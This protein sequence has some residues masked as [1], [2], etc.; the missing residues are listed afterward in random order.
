MDIKEE[1]NRDLSTIQKLLKNHYE[2][3]FLIGILALGIHEALH[4]IHLDKLD[5]VVDAFLE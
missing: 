2:R 4:L 5:P 1:I 3:A